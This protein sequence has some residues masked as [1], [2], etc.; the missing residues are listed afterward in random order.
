MLMGWPV[1]PDTL[2]AIMRLILRLTRSY[3]VA[4]VF[5]EHGGVR[6]LTTL[7]SDSGFSGF[8]PLANLLIRHVLE[9]SQSLKYAIEKVGSYLVLSLHYCLLVPI[10]PTLHILT[11][12][13]RR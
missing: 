4:E 10:E 5:S 8:F 1:N 2:H 11:I 3:E 7:T 12:N 6:Y 13:E 9:D